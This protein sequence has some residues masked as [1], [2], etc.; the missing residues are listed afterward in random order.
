MKP[1]GSKYP[2]LLFYAAR[3]TAEVMMSRVTQ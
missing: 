2:I 3:P 1:K